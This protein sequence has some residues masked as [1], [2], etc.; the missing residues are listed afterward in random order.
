[1]TCIGV[2]ASLTPGGSV[3]KDLVVLL[4]AVLFITVFYVLSVQD[5]TVPCCIHAQQV[6]L[7]RNSMSAAS[8]CQ[9]NRKLAF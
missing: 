9:T 1:M 6:P 5:C 7:P 8:E 2:A 4:F 3:M